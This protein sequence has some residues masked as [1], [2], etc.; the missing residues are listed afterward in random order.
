MRNLAVALIS[1]DL[2]RAGEP[3]ALNRAAPVVAP[4]IMCHYFHGAHDRE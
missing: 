3:S 1:R 4:P 2:Q